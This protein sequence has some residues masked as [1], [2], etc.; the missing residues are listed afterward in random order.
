M[1]HVLCLSSKNPH[2]CFVTAAKEIAGQENFFWSASTVSLKNVLT[3][4]DDFKTTF[5]KAYNQSETLFGLVGGAADAVLCQV[6]EAAVL[7]Q[8]TE[9]A[10]L[11][12]VAEAA[13]L[14]RG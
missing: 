7:Y 2:L 14:Y 3:S 5:F 9:A 12:R 4:G 6:P 8:V 11:Y 13:V 10:V 1:T